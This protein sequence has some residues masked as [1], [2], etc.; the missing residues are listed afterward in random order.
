MKNTEDLHIIWDNQ[1]P[2]P[3]QVEEEFIQFMKFILDNKIKTI[4]EIGTYKGGTASALL[5]LGCEVTSIDILKQPEIEELEKNPDYSFY[6]RD[7]FIPGIEEIYDLLF[8]DGDHSY[9]S[10]LKDYKEYKHLVREGGFIAFHD[11]VKSTLHE[12][13][14]CEVWK[15]ID[16][17]N[18]PERIDFI[19]DGNWGGI[20][21]IKKF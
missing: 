1:D 16:D 21:V 12:E 19:T 18:P 9:A 6:L 15:V 8:I 17:I 5:K 20:T 13:Q 10:C 11:V 7:A 3:W 14:G 2:K 4:L